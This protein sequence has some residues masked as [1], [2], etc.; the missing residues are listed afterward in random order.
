[1]KENKNLL[2]HLESNTMSF[3][4]W[5]LKNRDNKVMLLIILS[6]SVIQFSI[7]KYFYPQASFIHGDSFSY[8]DAANEN[9]SVSAYM[10]GY[11]KFLRLFSVFSKSDLVLAAFQYYLLLLSALF[12]SFTLFYLYNPLKS[13]RIAILVFVTFNPLFLLMGNL[14]SSDALFASLSLLWMATLLFILNK[15]TTNLII[16]HTILIFLAFIVRYNALTYL[17]LSVL[18]YLISPQSLLKKSVGILASI[19]SIGA[20]VFFTSYEFKKMTGEWQYSPFAGWLWANN[21]LYAYRYVDSAE[22]KPVPEKFKVIDSMA[23]HYFDISGSKKQQELA[24]GIA[25]TA[26]MWDPR[27]PLTQYRLILF[28]QDTTWTVLKK[29]SKMGPFYKEYGIWLIKTYP[30]YFL[31]YYIWPNANRYYAP[32]TEFLGSYNSNQKDVP[33]TA[34]TWFDYSSPK[35]TTRT[36]NFTVNILNFYP[37]LSGVINIV[38]LFSLISFTAL[39]GFKEKGEFRKVVIVGLVFWFINAAF[40]ISASAAALRFQSFPILFTTFISI[41]LIDWIASIAFLSGIKEENSHMAIS[42]ENI[43]KEKSISKPKSLHR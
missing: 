36:K 42:A 10:I 26:Y 6:I 41:I 21:A 4:A 32:P 39:G 5:L 17:I 23:R 27:L 15:P 22:R 34:V 43:F 28:K 19:V 9:S 12:L 25:G 3:R 16:W 20:F 14:V 8:I 33:R 7:F 24:A 1:M 13:T 29:W 40:T 31:K 37:Y 2:Q 11:S 35:L 38:M 30:I 18:V